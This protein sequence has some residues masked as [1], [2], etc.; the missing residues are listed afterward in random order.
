MNDSTAPI[1]LGDTLG[2]DF[3]TLP[4]AAMQELGAAAQTFGAVYLLAIKHDGETFAPLR[5]IA[6]LAELPRR[7]VQAHL[8]KLIHCDW[9]EYGGREMLP[10]S[11]YRRRRTVTLRLTAKAQNKRE[12]FATLPRWAATRLNTWGERAVFAVLVSAQHF[13]DAVARDEAGCAD[14]REFVNVR[15]VAKLTGLTTRAVR[16]ARGKLAAAEL[17]CVIDG[18][19]TL[20]QGAKLLALNPEYEIRAAD[21]AKP[22]T[23]TRPPCQDGMALG[24]PDTPGK[25]CAYP[26][27]ILRIPPEN[28]ALTPR[29]IL[30]IPPEKP[31]LLSIRTC[32]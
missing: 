15:T 1:R 14:G 32:Y 16:A 28:P 23:Q 24:H 8:H 26:R 19:P 12:P 5:K 13:V 17:I 9:V 27:K 2:K 20:R 30:R 3:L 7:T 11:T 22:V 21:R 29:K 6:E 18:D 31:A 10:G 4:R 25:T